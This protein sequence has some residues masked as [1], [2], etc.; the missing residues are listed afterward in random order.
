MG[1][2][3]AKHSMTGTG[4]G[5]GDAGMSGQV[6]VAA[7]V[8]PSAICAMSGNTRVGFAPARFSPGESISNVPAGVT[9]A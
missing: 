7:L 6:P 8:L 5:A 9:G 1:S 2:H 3:S 4:T